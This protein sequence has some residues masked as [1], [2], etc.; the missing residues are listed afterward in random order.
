M[1]RIITLLTDFGSSDPF[2]GIMKGVILGINPRVEIVDLCHGVSPQDVL[3]AAFLLHCSYRYFPRDSIHVLVVDPGV[4]GRRRPLLVEG[5]HGYY[6]APDNGVLSYLFASGEIRRVVEIT[7]D[8]YFLHP[9]SQ[10]FHGRDIFAP[11]AA[12]LSRGEA[13]DRFGR[14]ASACLRL[15]VPT[16]QKKGDRV[17]IGSVLH[18]DRFGNLVTNISAPDLS[19][20]HPETGMRVVIKGRTIHGLVDSY[21]RLDAGKMGTI[22]GSS[23]YLEIFSNRGNASRI[24]KARRGVAVRVEMAGRVQRRPVRKR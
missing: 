10:T 16:P 5:D 9:V 14:P 8:R 13:I 12:H 15:A 6:I 2:V 3:E 23:G 21:D 18:V 22:V 11:V 4:G 7:A 19:A 24:L 20:L 17:L 1:T